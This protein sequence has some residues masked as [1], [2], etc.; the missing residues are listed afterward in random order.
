M[1]IFYLYTHV[2]TKNISRLGINFNSRYQIEAH[3]IE[4][5]YKTGQIKF[6]LKAVELINNSEL[7]DIYGTNIIS[8]RLLIGENG[9]GKTSILNEIIANLFSKKGSKSTG[10]FITNQ[11]IIC[12]NPLFSFDISELEKVIGSRTLIRNLDI[13]N[14][15]RPDLIQPNDLNENKAASYRSNFLPDF[16]NTISLIYYSNTL[17]LSEISSDGYTLYG[18]SSGLEVDYMYYH[19]HSIGNKIAQDQHSYAVGLNTFS[20]PDGIMAHKIR[21]FGR[22]VDFL[23]DTS[24]R[25]YLPDP[26]RFLDYEVELDFDDNIEDFFLKTLVEDEEKT[27]SIVDDFYLIESEFRSNPQKEFEFHLFKN[28]FYSI[29]SI[30]FGEELRIKNSLNVKQSIISDYL[31]F[32]E[33]KKI[34]YKKFRTYV[35]QSTLLSEYVK[36]PLKLIEKFTDFFRNNYNKVKLLRNGILFQLNNDEFW[37]D[38]TSFIYSK[39]IIDHFPENGS[40][41]ISPLKPSLP[42]LSDGEKNLIRLFTGLRETRQLLKRNESSTIKNL[43]FLIDE[44]DIGIHPEWQR[45]FLN[46][47]LLFIN[48]SFLEYKCQLVLT[49]HSPFFTS[50]ILSQDITYLKRVDGNVTCEENRLIKTIGSNIY[51]LFTDSF[52]MKNGF[53]GAFAQDKMNSLIL[54]LESHNISKEDKLNEGAI[55][56]NPINYNW[57]KEK[58]NVFINGIGEPS[59]QSELRELFLSTFYDEKLIDLEIEKLQLLKKNKTK[60][61][62]RN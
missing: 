8:L 51:D 43:L 10:F 27:I 28:I 54:F 24:Y 9:S 52:Y 59:I 12:R 33:G 56:P 11:Y 31:K 36:E 7:Q 20:L 32:T 5:N 45:T 16:S 4:E 2:N 44:P 50:D 61:N 21:E 3:V 6:K 35:G 38:Y 22:T 49:S 25:K 55:N 18:N 41:L 62:D 53:I 46:S 39:E 48:G 42:D 60:R 19:D 26:E 29:L 34:T 15:V 30:V 58:A 17:N 13:I 57:S 47:F 14:K 23:M 1:E 40:F 37:H